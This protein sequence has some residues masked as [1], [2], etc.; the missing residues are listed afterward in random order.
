M[1]NE[2]EL[3]LYI[4][5]IPIAIALFSLGS[6]YLFIEKNNANSI[7]V[8]KNSIITI[9]SIILICVLLISHN[10]FDNRFTNYI[11][12]LWIL[13]YINII[14]ITK[15]KLLFHINSYFLLINLSKILSILILIN[16]EKYKISEIIP[17][18]ILIIIFLY[19][20]I[21]VNKEFSSSVIKK[22][23]I[24]T[25]SF[26]F[27]ILLLKLDFF[28]I[29][30]SDKI[31]IDK[32]F[33][34][35]TISSIFSVPIVWLSPRFQVCLRSNTSRKKEKQ[36][37]RNNKISSVFFTVIFGIIA[38]ILLG[39]IEEIFLTEFSTH[40]LILILSIHIFSVSFG[41]TNARLVVNHGSTYPLI[42]SI[43]S[44]IFTVLIYILLINLDKI[45]A[46]DIYIAMHSFIIISRTV[47]PWIM[48]RYL[49]KM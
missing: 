7:I 30:F 9:N 27:P 45:K 5:I 47:L 41:D 34:I 38:I 19:I 20:F 13:S 46:V 10:F 6:D 3:L 33:L 43:I 18:V 11:L 26:M 23:I 36:F 17:N 32:I 22:F 39:L 25:L 40:Y 12:I 15:Y 16:I 8:I 44:I 24:S 35:S 21:T 49:N 37:V 4:Q 29:S 14:S 28:L 31:E 48:L 2:K 42:C 1:D